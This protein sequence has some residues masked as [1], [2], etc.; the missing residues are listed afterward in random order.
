MMIPSKCEVVIIS[1]PFLIGS[2]IMC[3]FRHQTVWL[4]NSNHCIVKICWNTSHQTVT[5]VSHIFLNKTH[6][7]IQRKKFNSGNLWVDPTQC[8]LPLINLGLIQFT[9]IPGM[10]LLSC[11]QF[12]T[13][14]GGQKQFPGKRTTIFLRSDDMAT[15]CRFLCSYYLRV[16][17]I[18]LESP[19]T[20]ITA[21]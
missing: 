11:P 9:A 5:R 16:A 13:T 2:S 19:Q 6:D 14:K 10:K 12:V 4:Q 18:L 8:K 1:Q 21:R 15:C 7:P 17:F 20:S 3:V